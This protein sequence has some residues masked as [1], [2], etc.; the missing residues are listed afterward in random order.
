MEGL[1]TEEERKKKKMFWC[2]A[3]SF[4]LLGLSE[5]TNISQL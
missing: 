4:F 3:E 2:I 1:H 5:K